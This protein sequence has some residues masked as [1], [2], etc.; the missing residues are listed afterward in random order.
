LSH[1]GQTW[2]D[3][4]ALPQLQNGGELLVMIRVANHAGHGPTSMSGC[5]ASAST[6]AAECLMGRSTVLKHLRALTARGLLVPGDPRLVDH[7]PAD[8]RPPVYDLGGAHAKGCPGGHTELAECGKTAGVQIEHPSK[9]P[10]SAGAQSEHP[11]G[12]GV[13]NDR[14]RVFKSSTKGSKEL[15]ESS[16]SGADP[17]DAPDPAADGGPA[18]VERESAPAAEDQAVQAALQVLAA[19]EEALGGPALNGTRSQ[20]LKDAAEL[21]AARPLWWVMDR[22]R[23]L[24]RFGKSL[25]RHAEFS[26]VPF[27]EIPWP[28][29]PSGEPMCS[30]HPAFK[31]GDCS[32]C[33]KDERAKR[34]KSEPGPVDGAGLLARL[35]AAQPIS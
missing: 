27:A 17:S 14:E 26:T 20:L 22:A 32:P 18:D 24:P 16:L 30:R 9:K 13:Q 7:L 11:S 21:L 31:D 25:A 6:L 3:T 35:R 8:K 33:R 10:S 19:Y 34:E 4:V 28:A 15:K 12:A 5:Y 29:A 1:Q 23:E 2:V